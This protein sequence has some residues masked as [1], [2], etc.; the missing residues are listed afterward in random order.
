MHE[1]DKTSSSTM[2]ILPRC[3]SAKPY[4]R[5]IT[6]AGIGVD[7][8][9]RIKKIVDAYGHAGYMIRLETG[10]QKERVVNQTY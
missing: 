2:E 7:P 1:S 9:S 6:I 8:P 5:S 4:C 10:S 3:V